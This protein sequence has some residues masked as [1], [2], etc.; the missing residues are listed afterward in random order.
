MKK[1]LAR[2]L[3]I[4]GLLSFTSA[5]TACIIFLMDEPELEFDFE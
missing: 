4:L 2:V 5:S 1:L 3:A